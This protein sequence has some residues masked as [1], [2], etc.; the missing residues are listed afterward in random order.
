MQRVI[1]DV[2]EDTVGKVAKQIKSSKPDSMLVIAPMSGSCSVHAPSKSGKY[3]GYHRI[4]ME[5]WI[6]EDAIKGDSALDDFGLVTMLR[7]PKSRVQ[8]HL[9]REIED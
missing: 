2:T 7:L 5:V 4:K 9:I 1:F 8:P 3:K 6:P